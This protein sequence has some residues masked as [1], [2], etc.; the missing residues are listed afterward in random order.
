MCMVLWAQMSLPPIGI[1]TG[2]SI[3]AGFKVVIN[4]PTDDA[5]L[6]V[7]CMRCGLVYSLCSQARRA[8]QSAARHETDRES[9][10]TD[11]PTV[12]HRSDDGAAS[13]TSDSGAHETVLRRTASTSHLRTWSVCISAAG[14]RS[15]LSMGWVGLGQLGRDFPAV[16]GGLGRVG[17]TIAKVLKI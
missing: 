6:S 12:C 10:G 14:Y 1:W 8:L 9:A 4:R 3:F 16:F 17:S 7:A 11:R 15:E 5:T 13:G 2:S